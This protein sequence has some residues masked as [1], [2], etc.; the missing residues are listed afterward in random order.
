VARF[1]YGGVGLSAFG[2][3]GHFLAVHQ[4]SVFASVSWLLTV[5][6]ARSGNTTSVWSLLGA[7]FHR[8]IA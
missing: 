1:K 6:R 2:G 3:S 5:G 7:A 4:P 8:M